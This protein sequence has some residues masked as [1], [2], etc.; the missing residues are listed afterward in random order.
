MKNW[1]KGG[2]SIYV[3]FMLIQML[4][5]QGFVTTE[6]AFF[7]LPLAGLFGALFGVV[8][9]ALWT[10]IVSGIR[11]LR[12]LVIRLFARDTEAEPGGRRWY[13][14]AAFGLMVLLSLY[15]FSLELYWFYAWWGFNG[16]VAG[17]ILMPSTF[18]FPLIFLWVTG[19]WNG[20]IIYGVVV[21]LALLA[22]WFST[23]GK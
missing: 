5:L 18:V 4:Y 8:A 21:V 2:A 3:A 10:T 13:H 19:D 16:L 11:M 6:D 23:R 7:R 9:W 12:R 15:M 1:A 22:C 20:A 17:L 14:R